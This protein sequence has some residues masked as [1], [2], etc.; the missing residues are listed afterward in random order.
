M[1]Q[2]KA[3]WLQLVVFVL[4]T[5]GPTAGAEAYRLKTAQNG[6]AVRWPRW[7]KVVS[8]QVSSEVYGFLP[9]GQA[10]AAVEMAAEAWRG[11]GDVPAIRIDDSPAPDYSPDR[12]GGAVYVLT[13][14]PF[15]ENRLAI[16]VS[17]YHSDGRLVGVDVLINGEVN[18]GL[19]P[20]V[21]PEELSEGDRK[22]HDLA[23]VLTHEFGHVLGLDESHDAPEATMWPYVRAGETHQRYLSDDDENAVLVLYSRA[24]NNVDLSTHQAAASCAASVAGQELVSGRTTGAWAMLLCAMLGG[25]RYGKMMS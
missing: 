25:R 24:M 19:L 11:F 23:A 10:R 8:L 21:R 5:L 2:G 15:E 6:G 3:A 18:Y 17:S 13:P 14:W 1:V 16:T 9:M 20:E 22:K 7:Q 12:R 4:A